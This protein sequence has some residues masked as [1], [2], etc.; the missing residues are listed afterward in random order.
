[1]AF[2]EFS[3]DV[4]NT[5]CSTDVQRVI[6]DARKTDKSITR[7]TDPFYGK[8]EKLAR[9]YLSRESQTCKDLDNQ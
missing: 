2:D 8:L 1:M 6:T 7:K 9:D 5:W 3:Y 4:E